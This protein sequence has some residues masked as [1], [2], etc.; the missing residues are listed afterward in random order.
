MGALSPE[1]EHLIGTTIDGRYEI[2]H[3]LS[4][5]GF[6]TVVRARDLQKDGKLCAVKIFRYDLGDRDWIRY[7]FQHEVAALEQLSH[8]NIVTITG[9]GTIDTGAPYLVMEFIQGSSLREVLAQGPLPRLRIAR[10]LAQVASALALLHRASIFH[11]DLKPENLML[12]SDAAGDEQIVLIDFSIAI[13]KSPDETFHGISR[14]AG[15]IGYMAPEQVTGYADASTDI[16]SLAKVL[17]EM[18]SGQQ[19]AD[20]L[21][22]ATLDLPKH[23]RGYFAENPGALKADSIDMIAS[24]LAFDPGYRPKD[25]EGFSKPII[26]DL[27][28]RS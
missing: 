18:M 6:A 2:G 22:E 3:V 28:S 21:P 1:T 20:L 27:E 15:T 4:V 7:R 19:C 12:R 13:V 11:R 14:V 5:G 9:H 25:V 17:I 26:R 8:P 10:M 16:H 24:A 23:I